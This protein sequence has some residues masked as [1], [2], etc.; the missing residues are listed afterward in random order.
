MRIP[1]FAA[2]LVLLCLPLITPVWAEDNGTVL[3]T[4]ANRGLGLE[5]VKQLQAKGYRVIGTAR[6]PERATELKD[7]G[8]RIEQLDVADAMSVAALAKNAEGGTD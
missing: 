8:A 6:S 5:F 4:G 7:T 2:A 3:V 1:A